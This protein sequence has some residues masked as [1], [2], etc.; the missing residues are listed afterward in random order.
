MQI[1]K[2]GGWII[3]WEEGPADK[4]WFTEV[5]GKEN[6]EE[7]KNLINLLNPRQKA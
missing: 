1:R 6:P 2:G 4:G 3:I 7:R 5:V